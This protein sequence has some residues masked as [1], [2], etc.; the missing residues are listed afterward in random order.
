VLEGVRVIEIG[1]GSGALTGR[2]LAEL[3]AE[4]VRFEFSVDAADRSEFLRAL[5]GADVLIEALAPGGLACFGL[6]DVVLLRT[7]PH[8]VYCAI[9]PFGRSGPQASHLAGERVLAAL[10]G[11][12]A[13]G[14]ATALE[15]GAH[16]AALGIVVALIARETNGRGQLVD[17]SLCECLRAARAHG[18][19]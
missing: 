18:G 7:H 2:L 14:T 8:L 1:G 17:V 4:V 3:G 10:A 11:A 5:G 9:S 12:D 16:E 19:G 15:L 6:G 13:P